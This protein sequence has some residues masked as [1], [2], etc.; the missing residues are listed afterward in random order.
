M[1]KKAKAVSLSVLL[2][3][4]TNWSGPCC[5]TCGSDNNGGE[6]GNSIPGNNDCVTTASAEF[7]STSSGDENFHLKSSAACIDQGM[8]LSGSF[9]DDIDGQ[10]RSGTWDIGADEYV[11]PTA[12]EDTNLVVRYYMDEAESGTTPTHLLDKSGVGTAVDV[13][14]TYST[15]LS[16]IEVSGNRGLNSSS[17]SATG[18]AKTGALSSGNKIP[19]NIHG[20]QKVTLEYVVDNHTTVSTG[21]R[22]FGL[23]NGDSGNGT[24]LF[25]HHTTGENSNFRLNDNLGSGTYAFSSGRKVIHVV[26]DTTLANGGSRVR[27][28]VNGVNAGISAQDIAQNATVSFSSTELVF[29][30]RGS[31]N[32]GFDGILYY[33][34]IYDDAFDNGRVAEHYDILTADDDT[35]PDTVSNVYIYGGIDIMGGVDIQ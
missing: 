23:H 10:T 5:T 30:N 17:N 2:S 13:P 16:Y 32:R 22:V 26:L 12:L 24:V 8:D 18:I 20:A 6:S 34:A 4:T 33:A 29:M 25:T 31:G 35:P 28:Y 27:L 19:D 7:I 15:N 9:S 14:I 21:S 1:I 3:N 11:A